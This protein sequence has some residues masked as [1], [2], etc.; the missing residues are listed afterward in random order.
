MSKRAGTIYLKD[1]APPAYRVDTI[2]LCF[3]LGEETTRVV[4]RLALRR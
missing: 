4:S 1:Y 3:E 2:E